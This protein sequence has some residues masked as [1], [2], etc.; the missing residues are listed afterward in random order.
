V[1]VLTV[2]IEELQGSLCWKLV[3]ASNLMLMADSEESVRKDNEMEIWNGSY[4]MKG[5]L[6]SKTVN[7]RS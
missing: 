4:H 3:Y 7:H 1:I 5:S 2:I 6:S